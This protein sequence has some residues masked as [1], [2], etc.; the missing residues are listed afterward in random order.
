MRACEEYNIGKSISNN[1]FSN[2]TGDRRQPVLQIMKK[3]KKLWFGHVSRH[4]QQ[5]LQGA[6]AMHCKSEEKT[7]KVRLDNIEYWTEI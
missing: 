1:A 7:R 3:R 5:Y 2:F 4:V 6:A